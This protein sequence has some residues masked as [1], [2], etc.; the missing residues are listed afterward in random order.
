MA[1]EIKVPNVGE[2][3]TEVT[4]AEWLKQVGDSVA[5]D[6]PVVTLET[7]KANVD[8]PAP[9]AGRLTRILRDVND[10]AQVGEAL[11]VLEPLG[12]GAAPETAKAAPPPASPAPA[13]A[14][15]PSP[16]VPPTQAA[17]PPTPPPTPPTPPPAA[18]L[19]P[20]SKRPQ[21]PRR[22]APAPSPSAP[23][24]RQERRVAMT[25]IRRRIAE[26]LV[27]A[28]QN[29]AILT[30][31]GEVDMSAVMTLRS[32]HREAFL[33][34][35]GIKL[36]F[37]SFFIK[38]AIAGLREVPEVNAEIRDRDIVYR[39]Y[40]DICVAVDTGRGLMVPV[41]R[42]AEAMSFAEIERAIADFSTRAKENRLKPDELQGGTFTISNGGVFGSLLS[43]PIL[44][45]PQSGI[46]GMHA[47]QRRGVDVGGKL[48]LRPMMY[49]AMSYDH[50]IVDGR[51]AVT[52][53]RRI[54]ECIEEPAR[55]AL[56]V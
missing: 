3:I 46:L 42:D 50:R 32:E 47:I 2:S 26:R 25:P 56:D 19:P 28:Q 27:Q 1:I 38:A 6:E 13:R 20:V 52:C 39:D 12:A 49:L 15:P 17:P 5:E 36:G 30:T 18:T 40:Y 33:S 24:S 4:V 35:H 45:P 41:I 10:T 9:E 11:A 7:D 31:F 8:V 43:T 53:L 29:A 21:A 34:K 16:S 23:G 54:K 22:P 14:T 48:E 44:N 51:G 55:L 37:M